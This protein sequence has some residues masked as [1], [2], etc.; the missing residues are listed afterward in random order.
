MWGKREMPRYLFFYLALHSLIRIFVPTMK[1]SH[2]IS[3]KLR[4]SSDGTGSPAAVTI[5]VAGVALAVVVME[6]TL[7]IVA[8]FKDGIR[9]KLMGFDAQVSVEAPLGNNSYMERPDRLNLSARL[10]SIV[11]SVLPADAELRLTIRQPGMLKTDENFQGVI[12]VGQ[13]T[14]SSFDFEKAN[15]VEGEWPDFSAD[16]CDN[17]IVISKTLASALGL[18]LGDKVYSTFVIDGAVKIRR[19][20]VAAL[21]LSNFG[22]YDNTIV[23]ASLAALQRVAG[24]DSV[25]GNRID[26]RGIKA[27]NIEETANRLQQTL[28]SAVATR[29]LDEYYPVNDITRSGALY[30]NWLALLDTN[31]TVIF[32]LMLAV[33]GFTLVSSLF[34]LILERVRMIGILRSIGSGKPLVR[35]IFVD[36]GMRLVGRGLLLGNVIG[37]GLLFAERYMPFIPLDPQMYYLSYVP[38]TINPWA[39]LAL[40]AG[41]VAVSAL[42]LLIPASVAAATDPAKAVA[43]E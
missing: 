37:L 18:A 40:N 14:P 29:E 26:I 17:K 34:I 1:V 3:R 43:S 11:R 28:L 23:Y 36:M 19:H 35:G 13:S 27:S 8:G 38:V 41:V 15:I 6:L 5:A 10:D 42:I 12:Y 16:S 22:E 2:W 30:F 39:L 25:S 21:Y 24:M 31:V 32:I 20:T 4:L 7:G 33:A 9:S